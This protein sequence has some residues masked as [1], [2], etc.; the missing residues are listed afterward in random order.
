[1]CDGRAGHRE[2]NSEQR[3]SLCINLLIYL[4]K[5]KLTDF[6]PKSAA[7]SA[8]ATPMLHEAADRYA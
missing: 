2:N 3:A 5:I 7:S 4:M 6:G 1:L 8:V